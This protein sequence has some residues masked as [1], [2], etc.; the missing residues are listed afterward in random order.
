M[1]GKIKI[2]GHPYTLNEAR[3]EYEAL[4]KFFDIKQPR[5]NTAWVP[6]HHEVYDRNGVLHVREIR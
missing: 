6:P 5:S 1:S 2:N 4:K 3:T